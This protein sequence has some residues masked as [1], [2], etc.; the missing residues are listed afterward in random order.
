VL[1]ISFVAILL[2]GATL[3]LFAPVTGFHHIHVFGILAYMIWN[4][5]DPTKVDFM[6][7]E[8]GYELTFS[9]VRFGFSLSIW[10]A[11]AVMLF[12][13]GKKNKASGANISL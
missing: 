11:I 3:L 10:L 13:W 6:F 2:I 5:E 8:V 1:R 7:G 9:P 4:G 12:K